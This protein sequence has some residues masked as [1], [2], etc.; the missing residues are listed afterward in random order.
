MEFLFIG[1]PEIEIEIGQGGK[2]GLP[3]R[4][5]ISNDCELERHEYLKNEPDK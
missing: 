1:I 5:D 3:Q 2:S 4:Y